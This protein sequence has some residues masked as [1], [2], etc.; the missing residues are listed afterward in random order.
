M[1]WT[2]NPLDCFAMGVPNEKSPILYHLSS[3]KAIYLLCRT[4][5][6]YFFFFSRSNGTQSTKR[7][8]S[9]TMKK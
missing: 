5:F 3:A 1:E 6:C 9:K 8:K 7:K 4:S 2:N